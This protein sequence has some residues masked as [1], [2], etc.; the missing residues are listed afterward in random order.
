MTNLGVVP[1]DPETEVGKLRILIGD[2][3][4]TPVDD[5]TGD[6]SGFSDLQ[7][8]AYI[9]LGSNRAYAAGYAY[10]ALAA[11]FAADALKVTTDDESVD[12][13]ARA[14]SMRKIANEWFAQA[15]IVSD[16]ESNN[17]FSIIYPEYETGCGTVDAELESRTINWC[18]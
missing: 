16:N 15:A 8:E 3:E 7:L 18:D 14:E 2:V 9:S 6:F 12:L 11:Q 17:F 10:M 13:T 1:V 5:N 4:Y